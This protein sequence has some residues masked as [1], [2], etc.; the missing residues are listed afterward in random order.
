[1]IFVVQYLERL[2]CGNAPRQQFDE[3]PRLQYDVGVRRLARGADGHAPLDQ[4][5]FAVDSVLGEAARDE[6]PNFA[7]ISLAI[8]GKERREG[9]LLEESATR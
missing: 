1:M 7:Q 9:A 5:Q 3:I 8:F 4:I 6:G 2:R